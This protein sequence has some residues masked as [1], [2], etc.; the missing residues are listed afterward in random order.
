MRE[1]HCQYLDQRSICEGKDEQ[2]VI[3]IDASQNLNCLDS[4]IRKFYQGGGELKAMK[5][6][7]LRNGK[8]IFSVLRQVAVIILLS[9]CLGILVNHSRPNRL[10]LVADWSL[11][12]RLT[13]DS[14]KSM[15]LSLEE[16]WALCSDKKALFLD[17]RS[18]EDYALGHIRCA[19]NLPWEAF[20]EYINRLWDKIPDDAWIVTYCDGEHCSL[21]EDLAKELCSIG[22]EKVRVLPNGLKRWVEAGL[23]AEQG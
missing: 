14:R 10:P 20:D 21:S 22:Y 16:A 5:A 6:G 1:T 12:A 19:L 4:T 17:A 23:P 15:V 13:A 7:E 8:L 9:L 2:T 3:S 11:E 18:P